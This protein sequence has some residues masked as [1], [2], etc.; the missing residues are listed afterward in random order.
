MQE[1]Q[2]LRKQDQH[3]T[4]ARPFLDKRNRLMN[5]EKKKVKKK[6]ELNKEPLR[7]FQFWIFL[8]TENAVGYRRRST[9]FG[10]KW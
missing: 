3:G 6:T 7:I 2:Y 1:R 10:A 4:W 5:G 9:N 8:P